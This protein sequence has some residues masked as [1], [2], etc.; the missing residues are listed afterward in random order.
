MKQT[1]DANKEESNS[2]LFFILNISAIEIITL[3]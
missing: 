2:F 3:F 1:K